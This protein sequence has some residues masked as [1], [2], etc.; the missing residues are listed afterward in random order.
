M[1][2]AVD[3]HSQIASIMEVLANAAVAE[4]CK[5]VDDGYAVVQLEMSRSQKESE[6]LRR[7]IKLLELQVARYRAERVKPAEG[8]NGRFPG[9]RLLSRQ[10]GDSAAGPSLQGRT[11]FLNRGPGAQQSV[12]KTHPIILDQDP[13]QEVVTTTKTESAEP[14]EEGELLIVKV[15]GAT[16]TTPTQQGRPSDASIKRGDAQAPPS[17][18]TASEDDGRRLSETEAQRRPTHSG[19]QSEQEEMKEETGDPPEKLSPS[20]TLLDW[21]ECRRTGDTCSSYPADSAAGS[22]SFRLTG[23][24][25]SL[26]VGSGF[27]RPPRE[28]NQDRT[29]SEFNVVVVDSRQDGCSGVM[30]SGAGGCDGAEGLTRSKYPSPLCLQINRTPGESTWGISSFN[31][32]AVNTGSAEPQQ[33]HSWSGVQ[34]MDHLSDQSLIF[35]APNT[36]DQ[37]SGSQQPHLPF[38]CPFCPRRYSHQCKLRSHQRAHT[39]EKPYQC[40]QCGKRFGQVCSMKRHQMVHTG[41]RPYPCPHCGKQFST[42]TNLKV[43]QSVHTGEKRFN[44]S[45]CGKNFS[46]LSNLI[47][48]QALHSDK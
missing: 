30:S 28:Q 17:H 10:R 3:F 41:E 26:P 31:T 25:R 36:Q 44:C 47:R 1:S 42:S 8:F 18:P 45:K 32:P 22:S 2:S 9:F 4:I 6:C 29:E 12:Q 13:D 40:P 14:E 46:F 48:H 19:H 20:H 23:A 21:E 24:V 39:G 15:E 16:E 11:R 33:Q 34:Q 27:N 43:H 35:Q 38:A 5:V 37:E 7:K